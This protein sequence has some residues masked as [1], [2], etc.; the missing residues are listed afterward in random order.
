MI[1]EVFMPNDGLHETQA[2]DRGLTKS[3][4]KTLDYQTL[5][6]DRDLTKLPMIIAANNKFRPHLIAIQE[7]LK[8]SKADLE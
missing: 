3:N 1:R 5:Q 4:T 8:I 7:P 6:N 2:N